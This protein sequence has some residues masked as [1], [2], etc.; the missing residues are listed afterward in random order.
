MDSR[1]RKRAR[2]SSGDSDKDVVDLWWDA[3]GSEELIGNG[4]PTLRYTSSEPI[5]DVLSPRRY[6]IP[7]LAR[8]KK[9]RKKTSDVAQPGTLLYHMNNNIRTMRKLRT[10]H[11]KFSA[12]KETTNDDG[13][14]PAPEFPP[15]PGEDV[16]EVLDERPWR[17]RTSGVAVGAENAD[18]CLHWAGSKVLE[19]AGFQGTS[20]IAL[21]VLASVTSDF[22]QN[23]GRTIRYLSDKHANRMT[24]EEIVLH[25]LFE[26]GTAKVTELEHYIK[27]DI[28]RYGSR[29]YELEKKLAA[30]YTEAV[31]TCYCVQCSPVLTGGVQTTVEAWDDDA[32]FK[33][34]DDEEEEGEFV[35]GNFADSYG[36][37]FLGLREL[38]IAAEFG[39][40]TLTV[41]K[42]LLKGK[43]QSNKEG[44][45]V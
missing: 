16:E 5:P 22:F 33:M 32:L 29:I 9:K 14:V 18:E 8:R 42:K 35:M 19:H 38:G 28:V 34:E 20:K 39:L 44:P 43:K 25:T 17:S 1:P 37:D 15:L 12:I 21:D 36:E 24:A 31:R 7:Q 40:S 13:T 4:L 23:V 41:P 26:S 30:A 10:T 45:A 27:D 11:A 6:A 3:M 2:T